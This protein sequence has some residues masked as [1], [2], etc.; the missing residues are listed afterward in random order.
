M[1][2]TKAFRGKRTTVKYRIPIWNNNTFYEAFVTVVPRNK[3][4][5]GVEEYA[6]MLNEKDVDYTPEELADRIR[7]DFQNALQ[8]KFLRVIVKVSGVHTL[9]ISD[10]GGSN[11]TEV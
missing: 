9:V 4:A 5:T 2:Q 11:A 1:L 6:R 8:P 7:Y 3:T 10:G